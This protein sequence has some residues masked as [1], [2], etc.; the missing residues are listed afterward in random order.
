MKNQV[1]ALELHYLVDELKFLVGG[2]IN[3]VYHPDKNELLLQF[4]VPNKGKVLLRVLVPNFL[5]ITNYKPQ[6]ESPSGFCT[7]LRKKLYNIRVRSVEQKGCERVVEFI[8]EA[9]VEKFSLV[10][11]LF[12]KGNILLLQDGKILSAVDYP[13]WKDRTVKPGDVYVY[14]LKDFNLF[15]L[16][17]KELVQLLAKSDKESIVRAL[18]MDLGLGGLFAE[19]IC[20]VAGIDKDKSPKKIDDFKK[21]FKSIDVLR[22]N[23]VVPCVCD[24]ELLP[25]DLR[26]KVCVKSSFSSFN[27]LLDSELTKASIELA[28]GVEEKA[29]SKESDKLKRIISAQ[30]ESIKELEVK[31]SVEREKADLIYH[32]YQLVN[33]VLSQ[34]KDARKKF[35]FA[36]MKEK[37]KGH[38]L[39]KDFN[40]KDKSV[41]VDLK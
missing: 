8:L 7:Y 36:E 20:F 37:L 1:S 12:G 33:D 16:S 39:I 26:S 18:A 19:E 14:P 32:N 10:F 4:H 5:Y 6:Q 28:G 23:K 29:K 24:S 41:T 11:E 35:S 15:E 17:E 21:L 9:K 31:E 25:F 30:Q 40:A 13:I 2:K 3:Q 38:K 34:I 22:N 27:E